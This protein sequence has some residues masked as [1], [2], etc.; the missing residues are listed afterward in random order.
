MFEEIE[1]RIG[2][3]YIV[4]RVQGSGCGVSFFGIKEEKLVFDVERFC[5][6]EGI[7]EKRCDFAV[8]LNN[9]REKLCCILI[10]LKSG[11]LKASNVSEQL[12]GGAVVIEESLNGI[13]LNLI[14]LVLTSSS[15]QIER[16]RLNKARVPFRGIPHSIA[17]G[18]CNR[19]GNL[20]SA[21]GK[22]LG[23]Y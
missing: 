1:S 2:V 22:S 6:G 5:K 9:P 20:N 8:F 18:R 13:E 7:E 19:R 4:R 23:A 15:H 12:K 17:L 14:P 10:E 21:I 3:N 11:A 16:M